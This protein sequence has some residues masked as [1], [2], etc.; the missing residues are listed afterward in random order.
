MEDEGVSCL[1][2]KHNNLYLVAVTDVN[3]SAALILLYLYQL[4]EVRV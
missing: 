3:A 2:V 4:I 1:Y